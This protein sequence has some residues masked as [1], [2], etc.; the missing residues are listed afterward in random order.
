MDEGLSH[1]EHFER[2]FH[3]TDENRHIKAYKLRSFYETLATQLFHEF[4]P[5]KKVSPRVS[6]DFMLR[7]DQWLDGFKTDEDRWIAFRSIEY[8]FFAGTSEFEELYRCALEH[9]IEPWII[10]QAGID[11]FSPNSYD[12]LHQELAH[13]WPCPVT[14]SLRINGFLHITGFKGQSLRPD[15]QSLKALGSEEKIAAYIEKKELRYLVLLE[16]FSGSGGQICRTLKFVCE[17]FKGPIL[18]T[19]LIICATGDKAIRHKL[20]ELPENI[21]YAPV[22]VIADDCLVSESPSEAEPPLFRQLRHVMKSGF[23]IMGANL[24]GNEYGWEKTGSLVTL[25]SNCPNNT[26]PIYY[27][28]TPTWNPL[29]PRSDRETR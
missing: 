20:K 28:Q 26:P 3:S 8:L 12:Q 13:T 25:Y 17:N 7:L 5:T 23:E 18:L 21:S 29:F 19:P 15:W 16:D 11:I 24:E 4:E 22:T 9:K 27:H 2:N 10:D 14:D 6:R 1:I